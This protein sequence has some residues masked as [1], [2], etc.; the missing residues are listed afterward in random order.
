MSDTSAERAIEIFG[1]L[2]R[3]AEL[4]LGVAGV[5]AG[6]IVAFLISWYFFKRADRTKRVWYKS[7]SHLL[8]GWDAQK[9]PPDVELRF[10]GRQIP[11]LTRILIMVW[12]SGSDVIRTEDK[13]EA[14]QLTIHLESDKILDASVRKVR[15]DANR[16]RLVNCADGVRIDFDFLDKWD[17]ALIEVLYAGYS[18]NPKLT[19]SFKGMYAEIWNAG[20]ITKISFVQWL[21]PRLGMGYLIVTGAYFVCAISL[22]PFIFHGDMYSAFGAFLT[23]LLLMIA[24]IVGWSKL[25]KRHPKELEVPGLV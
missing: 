22:D 12:N 11:L 13:I 8:I 3:P 1:V 17:G 16:I 14:D 24:G 5:A 23:G 19:G 21:K 20:T 9:M 25:E 18:E 10:R 15:R 6:A 7:R 2:F 4:I